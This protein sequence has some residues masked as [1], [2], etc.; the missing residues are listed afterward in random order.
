MTDSVLG[1]RP[2]APLT[3][4]EQGSF[5]VG[6]SVVTA[7]GAYDGLATRPDGQT[8]HGD[9]AYVWYQVP[10]DAGR[11]P[12]VFQHGNQQSAKTWETTPDGREGFQNIFLRR[13]FP[14][15]V[16]DQPRRGRAGM[17]TVPVTLTAT[18]QDQTWFNIF[19]LGTW[20][21]L[22]DRVQFSRDPAALEQLFRQGT[23][24]TG[25]FDLELIADSVAELFARIGPGILVT[26][27]RGGGV[28][29]SALLKSDNIK[30]I[31]S[32][33]PGSNFPFP[34]NAVPG[35]MA[36]AGGSFEAYGVAA[37]L[38]ERLTRVPIVLY[39]GDFIPE[40]PSMVPGHDLWRVRLAMARL[41]AE[42]VNARGGDV[43]IV[44]LPELGIHGNTHFP[45]SDL[46]NV[47]IADVMETFLRERGLTAS[48]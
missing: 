22:F 14:V 7:P 20:P 28:G 32:Y 1:S 43:T 17:S 3:I 31:V 33:E 35:P 18:P 44:R 29:W 16:V 45:F 39:Y 48:R 38:F 21:N 37:P 11:Y 8:L 26:H 10:V 30:A 4:A 24:D 47:E 15:Y 42:A 12:I 2:Y 23:P 13:G 34:E 36:W 27:S 19:R 46:N 25:A 5:F 41:W 9:H 40:Q 6:G